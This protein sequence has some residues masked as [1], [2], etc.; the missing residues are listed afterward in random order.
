MEKH[1]ILESSSKRSVKDVSP[2]QIRVAKN[3]KRIYRNKT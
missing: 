3:E 1:C 2:E